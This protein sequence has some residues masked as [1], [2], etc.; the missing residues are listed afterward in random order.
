[1]IRE[2]AE[3]VGSGVLASARSA[4]AEWR[5]SLVVIVPMNGEIRARAEGTRTGLFAAFFS[6]GDPRACGGD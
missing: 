1:M 6:A 5:A 2:C 3:A 4:S